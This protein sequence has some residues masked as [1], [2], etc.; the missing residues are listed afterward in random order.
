[1]SL[2]RQISAPHPPVFLAWVLATAIGLAA[3]TAC[4][5]KTASPPASTPAAVTTPDPAASRLHEAVVLESKG[6]FSEARALYVAELDANPSDVDTT[7]RLANLESE[8]GDYAAALASFERAHA[9]GARQSELMEAIADLHFLAG[10]HR[11]AVTWYDRAAAGQPESARILVR[12]ARARAE[13]DVL[14]LAEADCE[15]VLLLSERSS[16]RLEARELLG[17]ISL[18]R[19]DVATAARRL[20]LAVKSGSREP[21]VYRF[22]AEYEFQQGRYGVVLELTDPVPERAHDALAGDPVLLRWRILSLHELQRID[23]ARQQLRDAR[24]VYPDAPEFSDLDELFA[25]SL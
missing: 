21:A 15:Q 3:V 18:L 6:R 9:L 14:D 2:L 22:L 5:P 23:E 8:Q 25:Q 11:D 20:R 16:E 19:G 1:M 12:R 10:D 24:A 17:L 13:T 4:A 7:I